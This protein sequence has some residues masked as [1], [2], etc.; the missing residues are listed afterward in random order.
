MNGPPEP[1]EA[2][3]PAE[4][5]LREHLELLRTDLP[6]PPAPMV[7]K[8]V[9]AARWQRAVRQPLTAI[10]ALAA[11]VGDGFRL[12]LGSQTPRS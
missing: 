7:A 2:L 12:L 4:R 6:T 3:S 8:I 1:P 5:R 9:R 10:G 11:A